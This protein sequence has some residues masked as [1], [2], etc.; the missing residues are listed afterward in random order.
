MRP[1]DLLGLHEY[2][3][4]Q[5]DIQ[6][7]YHCG[8]WTLVSAL[9]NVPIVVTEC[10]RDKWKAAGGGRA[11]YASAAAGGGAAAYAWAGR[12]GHR[13]RLGRHG[14]TDAGHC[15]EAARAAIDRAAE[16]IG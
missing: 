5:A 14:R 12:G 11:G 15:S 8:R 3:I 6:N 16:M 4:D 13:T 1:G 2:W 10:N 9:A 7:R